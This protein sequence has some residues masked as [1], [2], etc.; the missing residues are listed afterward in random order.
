MK[1]RGSPFTKTL[2]LSVGVFSGSHLFS[3]AENEFAMRNQAQV[4]QHGIID[5]ASQGSSKAKLSSNPSDLYLSRLNQMNHPGF[6]CA[7][8]FIYWMAK[9]DG[10]QYALTGLLVNTNSTVS[11]SD[12]GEVSHPKVEWDPG[13]KIGLGYVIDPNVWDLFV[14]WT[15]YRTDAD[16][17]VE[18][19]N[20]LNDESIFAEEVFSRFL[21]NVLQTANADWNLQYNTLDFSIGRQFAIGTHLGLKPFTGLRAAWI[22]QTYRIHGFAIGSSPP[23]ENDMK[24]KANFRGVGFWSGI[25]ATWNFNRYFSLF[26]QNSFSLFYGLSRSSERLSNTGQGAGGLSVHT[27]NNIHSMKSELEFS[28]GL[29]FEMPFNADR[30]L[31]AFDVAWEYL[32]WINMNR[33]YIPV[34]GTDPNL[35]FPPLAQYSGQFSYI[36]GDLGLMGLTAGAKLAF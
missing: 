30:F 21:F 25:A 12:Q 34:T 5:R 8:D 33:F 6:Y 11:I 29:R 3:E 28:I 1:R 36:N 14:N 32:N 16:G 31:F 19:P 10:L 13:F 17:G 35:G 15:W 26:S 4:K 2:L 9:E 20:A 23:V 7:G 27:T 22:N 24:N 18:G